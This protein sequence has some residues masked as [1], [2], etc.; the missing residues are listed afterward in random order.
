M[1]LKEVIGKRIT[2]IHCAF[3]KLDGWINTA[4]CFIELDNQW[5]ID[6]PWGDYEEHFELNLLT[7]APGAISMFGKA[8]DYHPVQ[9]SKPAEAVEENKQPNF[10]AQWL[11]KLF[12]FKP[13]LEENVYHRP[14]EEDDEDLKNYKDRIIVDFLWAEGVYDRKGFFLLD[15][16][17]LITH[18]LSSPEGTGLEGINTYNSI[19]ELI[20]ETGDN[21]LRL[22][23]K[24]KNKEPGN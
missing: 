18:T 9:E 14:Q 21:Y 20:E 13:V 10:F 7:I 17:R 5:V 6:M 22:T 2:N 19:E 16:G 23:D 15:S 3:G 1:L 4:D 24:L 12:G 8:Y 11:N